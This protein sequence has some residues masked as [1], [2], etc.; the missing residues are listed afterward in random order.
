[1]EHN[2]NAEGCFPFDRCDQRKKSSAILGILWKPLS[3]ERSDCSD[4]SDNDR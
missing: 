3:S 2:R 1:M 4:L